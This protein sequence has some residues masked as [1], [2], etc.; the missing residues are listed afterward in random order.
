MEVLYP[1]FVARSSK[2]YKTLHE[3]I[4]SIIPFPYYWFW[5]ILGGATFLITL[6]IFSL[7]TKSFTNISVFLVLFTVTAWQSIGVIWARNKMKLFGN[8]FIDLVEWP[9]ADLK[10]RY[11]EQEAIIFN[12]KKM[13]ASGILAVAMAYVLGADQCGFHFQGFQTILFKI[14]YYLAVYAFGVGFYV[15]IMT[16]SAVH[17]IGKLSLTTNVLFSKNIQ[18]IGILYSKFT[19]YAFSIY[20]IWVI[21]EMLTPLRLSSLN[22]T[23]LFVIF[24]VLLCAYFI[25]PQ[26]SI[27]QLMLRTKMKKIRIFSSKLRDV[28]DETFKNPTDENVLSLNDLLDIQHQLDKMNEW[29]FSFYEILHIALIIVIPLTVLTLEVMHGVLK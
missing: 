10:K 18:T 17:K 3:K 23:I 7:T 24:A 2:D 25:L 8:N 16:A 19:I 13:I 22:R 12:D 1:F 20:I 21:F 11:D 27:H 9:K 4:L 29:P 28:A 6:A 26:Y 14:V 15:M 5:A